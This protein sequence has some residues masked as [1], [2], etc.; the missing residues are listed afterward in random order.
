[1]A[2]SGLQVAT[3]IAVAL[4][5]HIMALVWLAAA[6]RN[7]AFCDRKIYAISWDDKQVR[8]EFRNSLHTPVHAAVLFVFLWLGFFRNTTWLSSFLSLALTTVW[9]EIWHYVSHRMFHIRQLH[10]IHRE[11]HRSHV[12]TPF[13]ALSFSFP[14]KLI[15]DIGLIAP[16]AILDRFFSLNFFGVAMWYLG[17]LVINSFSHANFEFKSPVFVSAA[18]R[19]LTSTTY[20]SLHHARYTGNYGLGT[21]FLD[22][23]FGTEWDDYAGVFL[24]VTKGTPVRKL[25]DRADASVAGSRAGVPNTPQKQPAASA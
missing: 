20:H 25:R 18:G 15:F 13:T 3:L 19:I 24:Q 23:L 7:W 5:G 22:R 10:W 1:M 21:R 4:L 16:L 2:V 17:Y 8:R 6:R 14:E 12:S 9:A 11:H